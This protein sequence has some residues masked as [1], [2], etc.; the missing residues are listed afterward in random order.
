MQNRLTEDEKLRIVKLFD[1]EKL[2]CQAI[3]SRF[4]MSDAAIRGVLVRAGVW[5]C[6]GRGRNAR[7]MI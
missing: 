1:I 2:S 6:R 7:G 5:E 3:A 4:C